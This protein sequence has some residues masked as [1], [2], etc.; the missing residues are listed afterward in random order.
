MGGT[1]PMMVP[2]APVLVSTK[3]GLHP[4]LV[5]FLGAAALFGLVIAGLVVVLLMN[6]GTARI[7]GPVDGDATRTRVEVLDGPQPGRWLVATEKVG[8]AAPGEVIDV[9]LGGSCDCEP[10]PIDGSPFLGLVLGLLLVVMFV[11]ALISYLRTR[12]G[13]SSQAR[14]ARALVADAPV[15]P[16]LLVPSMRWKRKRPA[17]RARVVT[18]T[19]VD[20]GELDL[21]RPLAA[22]DPTQRWWLV[23]VP[24][25][26][27]PVA[28]VSEGRRQVLLPSSPLQVPTEVPPWSPTVVSLLGW[29]AVPGGVDPVLVVPSQGRVAVPAAGVGAGDAASAERDGQASAVRT[30]ARKQL[31]AVLVGWIVLVVFLN[32]VQAPLLLVFV[33]IVAL[34][35]LTGWLLNRRFRAKAGDSLDLS[36]EDQPHAIPIATS[37]AIW[38]QAGARA[39]VYRRPLPY[40]AV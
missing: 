20:L 5:V 14:A 6:L 15:T 34:A 33:G 10:R 36:P 35:P 26:G 23:G 30:T 31:L 4:A 11:L 25:L 18:S 22:F 40:G 7:I 2:S 32:V 37:L 27:T 29:D 24:Q 12:K 17:V 3:R 21:G 16:V 38:R 13:R 28:L 8:D 19:G 9:Y 1:D 39:P